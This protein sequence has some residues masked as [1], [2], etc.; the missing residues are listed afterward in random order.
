MQLL[1]N[2]LR[3]CTP[4]PVLLCNPR[5]ALT[6]RNVSMSALRGA[7][8]PTSGRAQ[9]AQ[10]KAIARADEAHA[11]AAAMNAAAY[12]APAPKPPRRA[13]P[14]QPP[15]QSAGF[16][17]AAVGAYPEDEYGA[18]DSA[19]DAQPA[20]AP[21]GSNRARKRPLEDDPDWDSHR[22]LDE[23]GRKRKGDVWNDAYAFAPSCP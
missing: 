15:V 19:A 11:A 20:I 6:D 8:M 17:G 9:A 23:P 1:P 7:G 21:A 10:E 4:Y 12:A 16:E 13:M 5:P 22:P 18:E 14:K 3:S 2:I